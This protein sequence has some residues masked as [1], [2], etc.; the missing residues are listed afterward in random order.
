[1]I[2]TTRTYK[3]P[4]GSGGWIEGYEEVT[5]P[6]TIM[7]SRSTGLK[8]RLPGHKDSYT[9]EEIRHAIRY[10][11]NKDVKRAFGSASNKVLENEFE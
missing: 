10:S 7:V 5:Y 6:V 9:L 1:M 2:R 11:G 4:Y 3:E 8:I